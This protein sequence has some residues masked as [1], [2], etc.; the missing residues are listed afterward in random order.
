MSPR[1]DSFRL[2]DSCDIVEVWKA[3]AAGH[4]VQKGGRHLARC[5]RPENHAHGDQNPSL[6]VG[7]KKNIAWCPVCNFSWNPIAL[8]GEIHFGVRP[9]N[10]PNDTF[11]K[12]CEWLGQRFLGRNVSCQLSVVGGKKINNSSG[13]TNS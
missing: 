1:I 7:G 12:C 2:N 8:V 10:M 6:V 3:L 9:E 4:L 5:L 11:K 13:E